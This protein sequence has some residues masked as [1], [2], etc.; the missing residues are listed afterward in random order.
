MPPIKPLSIRTYIHS[1]NILLKQ[2]DSRI[3]IT[4]ENFKESV[5]EYLKS[6]KYPYTIKQSVI[7]SPAV[8]TSWQYILQI[9][10]WLLDLIEL[11]QNPE[12]VLLPDRTDQMQ[13]KL[14][15]TCVNYLA[16]RFVAFNRTK[17]EKTVDEDFVNNLG[18]FDYFYILISSIILIL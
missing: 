7:K 3:S 9:W 14:F 12:R 1:M 2:L 13:R 10:I 18:K 17:D 11:L 15:Y 16:D 5:S 4:P 8:P 6:F